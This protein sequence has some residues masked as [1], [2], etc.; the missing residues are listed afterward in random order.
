MK[1]DGWCCR[2]AA[3]DSRLLWD[4]QVA[5]AALA[6]EI[7]ATN[8]D[9]VRELLLTAVN[10]GATVLIADMSRT[11]FCDSAGMTSVVRAYRRANES[12][13]KFR[14]VADSPSVLRVLEI[15]GIDRLIET[16]QTL[17]E[18][19]GSSKGGAC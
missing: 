15:T 3:E 2:V 13:T 10:Q 8:A 17:D 11:T 7:D 18:A 5:V 1:V 4:G 14:L 19:L 16:Y 12:G 9:E 6:A